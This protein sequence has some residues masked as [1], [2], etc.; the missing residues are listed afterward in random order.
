VTITLNAAMLY[1]E[2]FS[3]GASGELAVTIFIFVV[4]IL[5]L[6]A[7]LYFMWFAAKA[8][9]I[10]AFDA[11]GSGDVTWSEIWHV[12]K[13]Q[14]F[15]KYGTAQM[16]AWGFSL[17]EENLELPNATPKDEPSAPGMALASSPEI[18]LNRSVN[19]QDV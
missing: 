13:K 19:S 2:H 9:F 10:E 14:M 11:D 8:Q 6:A 18:E 12:I 1:Q 4:N 5:V 7:F 15:E 17:D 16:T 3:M